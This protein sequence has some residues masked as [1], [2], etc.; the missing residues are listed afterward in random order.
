MG[1]AL[2]QATLSSPTT[3]STRRLLPQAA[4]DPLE[5]G[6]WGLRGTLAW[7]WATYLA[8]L[9]SLVAAQAGGPEGRWPVWTNRPRKPT[10]PHSSPAFPSGWFHPTV[11]PAAHCYT[12][13]MVAVSQEGP[14]TAP[15]AV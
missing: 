11:D 13:Q 15:K 4:R 6:V 10:E 1:S 14:G 5:A 9:R 8:L 2:T 7:P 12:H 3:H